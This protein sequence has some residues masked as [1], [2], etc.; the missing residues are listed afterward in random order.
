MEYL[1]FAYITVSTVRKL[2]N[3]GSCQSDATYR[4]NIALRPDKADLRSGSG[5][6]WAARG[7]AASTIG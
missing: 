2:R 1:K 7:R 3:K 5:G 4:Q 6:A